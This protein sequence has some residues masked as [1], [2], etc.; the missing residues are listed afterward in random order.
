[1]LRNT[2]KSMQVIGIDKDYKIPLIFYE[3]EAGFKHI[4]MEQKQYVV[5]NSLGNILVP[6]IMI[7]NCENGDIISLRQLAN[8]YLERR[9]TNEVSLKKDFIIVLV[10]CEA[11]IN[12]ALKKVN[13]IEELRQYDK[14]IV[15]IVTEKEVNK[16]K[17]SFIINDDIN[18]FKKYFENPKID[19]V[20]IFRSDSM[21]IGT[22]KQ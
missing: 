13:D 17:D 15:E 5:K 14:I 19:D 21:I 1:M 11:N 6:H 2:Q 20:V 16:N 8:Y 12:S 22:L 10:F 4:G 9:I 3:N 7:K 18:K